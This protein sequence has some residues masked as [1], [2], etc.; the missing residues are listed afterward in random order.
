M[1]LRRELDSTVFVTDTGPEFGSSR[2]LRGGSFRYYA[3]YCRSAYRCHIVPD[4]VGNNFGFRLCRGLVLD[5]PQ[6]SSS[7]SEL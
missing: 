7:G 2:V 5:A 4:F 6:S 1:P 3:G